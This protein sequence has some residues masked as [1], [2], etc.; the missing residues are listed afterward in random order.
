MAG[1]LAIHFTS[2]ANAYDGDGQNIVLDGVN[3]AVIAYTDA[4][5][6]TALKLNRPIWPR[7]ISERADAC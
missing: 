3:D 4:V 7:F 5:L 1:E 2:V 6:I